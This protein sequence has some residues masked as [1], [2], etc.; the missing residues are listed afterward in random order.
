MHG[1][2]EGYKGV[3]PALSVSAGIIVNTMQQ[4]NFTEIATKSAVAGEAQ[5]KY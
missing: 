3:K 5:Q 4:G 2:E 1:L